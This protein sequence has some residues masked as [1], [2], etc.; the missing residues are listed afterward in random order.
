MVK[1]FRRWLR[2]VIVWA[3]AADTVPHDPAALDEAA[4]KR[5]V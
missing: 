4:A 5:G 3:L 1:R 2:S